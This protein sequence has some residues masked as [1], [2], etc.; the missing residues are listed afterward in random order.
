MY[1]LDPF[2]GLRVGFAA[3]RLALEAQTVMAI[4]IAGMAGFLALPPGE[5]LR[6]VNEKSPAWTRAAM[7]SG[8]V[9]AGG[10]S[11]VDAMGAGMRP[12][13]RAASSN[14]RRLSRRR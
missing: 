5:A 2:S 7:D 6:M 12:L 1:P 11:M 4:R 3:W 8:K 10:G 9:I 13:H 14:R